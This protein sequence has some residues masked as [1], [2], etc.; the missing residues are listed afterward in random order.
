MLCTTIDIIIVIIFIIDIN[1]KLLKLNYKYFNFN[2]QK[3]VLQVI[4]TKRK[5]LLKIIYVL[6]VCKK[7]NNIEKMQHCFF[8]FEINFKHFHSFKLQFLTTNLK[9]YYFTRFRGA[10]LQMV[11]FKCNIVNSGEKWQ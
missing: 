11:K 4:K 9:L 10:W 8:K 7:E 1:Y 6:S 2:N 5:A 3:N